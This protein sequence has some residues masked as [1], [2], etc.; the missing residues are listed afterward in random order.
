ME[1]VVVFAALHWERRAVSRALGASRS[2]VA[3]RTWAIRLAGG[4]S[5][6]LVETGMGTI[7]ARAAALEAPAARAWLM[8]GCAGALV[9]WLGRGQA[10]AAEDVIVLDDDGNVAERIP[11]ASG[12]LAARAA[13]HGVRVVPGAIATTPVVLTDAAAKT[14]AERASGALVVDMESGALA[15]V[16]RDRGIPFHALRVVLD[17]ADEKLPFGPDVFDEQTGTL[18]V[19]RTI[20]AL[21]PPSR[22]PVAVRLMRGQRAAARTLGALAQV[23]ADEG[24]PEAALTRQAATA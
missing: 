18:H 17:Q 16:A 20:R 14:A 8:M 3:P 12:P 19:G 7:R 21:A 23:I 9:G 24:L 22:W 5:G 6:V 1:D 11:A 13:G 2:P 15:A 4:R 10:V